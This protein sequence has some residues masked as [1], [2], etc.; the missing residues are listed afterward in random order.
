M[1]ILAIRGEN[2]ASLE[3][4]FDID[5][6]AEPLESAGIFAITGPTGA[7][8][9]T[10]LDAMGLGLF[11]TMARL[12]PTSSGAKITGTGDELSANDVRAI[13]RHGANSCFAEVDF[14]VRGTRWRARWSVDRARTGTLKQ[15]ERSLIN[16]DTGEGGPDKLTIVRDK[17]EKLIGLTPDQFGRAVVLAQGEFEKFLNANESE[18]AE[19][20]ETLTGTD[21]YS[22]VGRL[23]GQKANE[24][25]QEERGI[26][27]QIRALD[28]LNDVERA[29]LEAEGAGAAAALL[30]AQQAI[31]TLQEAQRWE[32]VGTQLAD[33]VLNADQAVTAAQEAQDQAAPRRAALAAAKRA[34]Q[35]VPSWRAMQQATQQAQEASDRIGVA[36]A[37]L[38]EQ[39]L[40]LES[41]VT[42]D[43]AASAALAQI[44]AEIEAIRP[45]IAKARALDERITDLARRA[46]ES[47]ERTRALADGLKDA[48]GTFNEA[49]T[50]F[51]ACE[52]ELENC[53]RWIAEHEALRGLARESDTIR[54]DLAE[55][56][57][58]TELLVRSGSE[59]T[60]ARSELAQTEERAKLT[61]EA[62]SDSQ[63]ALNTARKKL[64]DAEM[65]APEEL[66][67][68][69]LRERHQQLSAI[70][71]AIRGMESAAN[72]LSEA[73][74][75]LED[76][77]DRHRQTAQKLTEVQDQRTI[78]A[79]GMPVL[80]AEAAGARSTADRVS[81]AGD[82]AAARL[83][84]TLMPGEPC[85][86]CGSS[87]HEADA[88]TALLNAPVSEA[89][90]HAEEL[91]AKLTEA[92]RREAALESEITALEGQAAQLA[93]DVAQYGDRV[94]RLGK[95]RDE[96]WE[97]L[98]NATLACGIEP[99][100]SDLHAMVQVQAE[101][102]AAQLAEGRRLQQ[103][104][105]Q[106]RNDEQDALKALET[107][108]S[109][110]EE[111]QKAMQATST[112]IT[113]LEGREA[114]N[115]A[116]LARIDE[117]L[118]RKL[119]ALPGVEA[120]WQQLDDAEAWLNRQIAEWND[121]LAAQN[122]S[123]TALPRLRAA[124]EAAQTAL[125][126]ART[127][128]EG[129]KGECEAI[130]KDKQALEHERA[131]LLAGETVAAVELRLHDRIAA[132][133]NDRDSAQQTLGE[134]R[135][136]EASAKAALTSSREEATRLK[137][138]AEQQSSDFAA[139]LE[140]GQLT[141][142]EIEAAAA[143]EADREE[144]EMALQ[145]L[146]DA[147]TGAQAALQSRK[148]DLA[149]HKASD[150]PALL[151]EELAEA[152]Q[153]ARA[154]R[155]AAEERKSEIDGRIASDDSLRSRTAA[156]R[157]RHADWR[158]EAEPWLK[159]GSLIGD[160]NGNRFR[161][162]AQ[163]LTLDRLL[164]AANARLFDL[165]PRYALQRGGGGDM[166][167]QVVDHDLAGQVRGLH[168]L[169]GGERFLVSL[170]LA[171]GL[172][173]MSSGRG[174]RIESLFIDEGFGS[175]DPSSLG[176]ALSVLENL[177][178]TGRRVGVI[179]HVEDLKE[180]IPVKILVDVLSPGRSQLEVVAG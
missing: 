65:S 179:S 64:T 51:T 150:R 127:R 69:E 66:H 29:E 3:A 97:Q 17:I 111:A 164:V 52:G 87:E 157:A 163:G 78:L 180:R 73:S 74:Q 152:L 80:T 123:A 160:A 130:A 104:V 9:S 16:L 112:C 35:L 53:T 138:I 77:R 32:Q 2:L 136:A 126:V 131:P 110:A 55:H 75:A 139:A 101:D 102:V 165:K 117:D 33:A 82:A 48:E 173:E 106:A 159:L 128:Q 54:A 72:Q 169:S 83:R 22:R 168:N 95:A 177:H 92:Q 46:S 90:T 56:R 151:G 15:R 61:A 31:E 84:A 45:E 23:A 42:A 11:D 36:E 10:L 142:T 68:E 85:P 129:L 19:L 176:Q 167:I 172:A 155:S 149:R 148:T 8:K 34:A 39:S 7:G 141:A 134:V 120:G 96:A 122:T 89:V 88:L 146:S 67:L 44:Q 13:M 121:A 76:R 6:T 108:R 14:E 30:A 175:L 99:E 5:F 94:A 114:Q 135:A 71:A 153:R 125:N 41:A 27:E 62:R 174:V 28:G 93:T 107:A 81:L 109:A 116:K 79:E 124:R 133:S 91:A 60:E 25:K 1:R 57:E 40:A 58:L 18:R 43:A 21:I 12:G 140:R 26:L 49:H 143:T 132:A 178:A 63:A 24:L 115:R 158:K 37:R 162:Y 154:E 59:L 100:A 70:P 4:P 170:A 20:L 105:Q 118:A 156:L 86:V 98:A 50:A 147:V 119:N 38:A 161:R 171:L 47:D 166:V 144:E 103:A 137:D 145:A 113:T